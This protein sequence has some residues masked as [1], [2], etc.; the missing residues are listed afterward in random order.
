MPV[1]SYNM[2]KS[3]L[4]HAILYKKTLTFHNLVIFMKSVFNKDENSYYYNIIL[5]KDL[6]ELPKNNDNK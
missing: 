4:S 2:Q 1:I 3:K 5:E 6:D